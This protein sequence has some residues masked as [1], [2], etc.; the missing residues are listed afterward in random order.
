MALVFPTRGRSSPPAGPPSFFRPGLPPRTVEDFVDQRLRNAFPVPPRGKE[1][2]G[3]QRC[4]FP[5]NVFLAVRIRSFWHQ[6]SGC[7]DGITWTSAGRPASS[8]LNR[9]EWVRRFFRK[10]PGPRWVFPPPRFNDL[11][12][13]PAMSLSK[14][15]P[16]RLAQGSG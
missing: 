16:Q 15:P 14:R 3:E 9:P 12:L 13:D 4:P 10:N 6:P 11:A 7:R 2:P 8:S 5:F 1:N